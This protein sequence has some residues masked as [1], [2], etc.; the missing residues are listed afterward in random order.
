MKT[1]EELE[2]ICTLI[3]HDILETAFKSGGGH[4]APA[5]SCVEILVALYFGEILNFDPNDPNN[6]DRDRFILSKGHGC[7]ALYA[8]LSR[9]G[10]IPYDDI[11]GLCGHPEI[12]TPGIEASTGSLGHG[13]S[14]GVG[15]ALANKLNGRKGRVYVL[16]GDGE[17]QE[18]TTWEAIR[19]AVEQKL[20]NLTI[21]VDANCIQAIK[22]TRS[23]GFWRMVH[24]VCI[25]EMIDGHEWGDLLRALR[26][27]PD[28]VF[29]QCVI[30]YTTKGKGL[31]F[32]ENEIDW[33]YRL[34]ET[35]E[36]LKEC[37]DKY[38]VKRC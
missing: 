32:M 4:I 33:H 14:M 24:E 11:P 2:N 17:C 12:D 19:F 8:V 34:P 15:M 38:G 37:W 30:A 28:A 1:I 27:V 10:L 36:E 13:L 26:P 23:I 6:P 20:N 31:S 35:D 3:R 18:G 9:L 22:R 21:I 5:F 16:M 25:S 29:S 7:L